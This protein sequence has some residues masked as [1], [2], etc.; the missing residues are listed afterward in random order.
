MDKWSANQEANKLNNQSSDK[1][2]ANAQQ[3]QEILDDSVDASANPRLRGW[4]GWI[5]K[6][7]SHQVSALQAGGEK[8]R[9]KVSEQRLAP[10]RQAAVEMY[11]YA[12]GFSRA[13]WAKGTDELYEEPDSPREVLRKKQGYRV[14]HK[15]DLGSLVNIRRAE[16]AQQ[17][18]RGAAHLLALEEMIEEAD[19]AASESESDSEDDGLADASA[20]ALTS[21]QWKLLYLIG[22]YSSLSEDMETNE[23]WMPQ[24]PLMVLIYEGCINKIFHY[25]YSPMGEYVGRH[26]IFFNFSQ[27]GFSDIS[28]LR[29]RGFIFVLKCTDKSHIPV[30]CYQVSPEGRNALEH[31]PKQHVRKV[32]KFISAP[33]AVSKQ[34]S[35]EDLMMVHWIDDKFILKSESGFTRVTKVTESE[36]VSYVSSPHLPFYVR[37][38]TGERKKLTSNKGRAKESTLG[39]TNLEGE[40]NEVLSFDDV[41]VILSEWLPVG[42]NN[43]K[44]LTTKVG[45][46]ERVST[47][48]YSATVDGA[49]GDTTLDV[50]PGLTN[51]NIVDII[52][53]QRCNL[54]AE[55]YFPE[56]EGIV[57]V[58]NFGVH[59]HVS[60]CVFCGIRI[61]AIQERIKNHISLDSL[62]RVLVDMQQ[63]SSRVMDT[64]LSTRQRAMLELVYR[65]F[66]MNRQKFYIIFAAKLNPSVPGEE[67]LDR[68]KRENELR[69]ILGEVTSAEQIDKNNLFIFGHNGVCV[70]GPA[71]F[72]FE[73]LLCVYAMLH[74]HHMFVGS[75]LLRM[76]AMMDQ[77]HQIRESIEDPKGDPNIVPKVHAALSDLSKDAVHLEEVLLH[78]DEALKAQ[79]LPRVSMDRGDHEQTPRHKVYHLLGFKELLFDLE[80]RSVDVHK[81][82]TALQSELWFVWRKSDDLY[83][84]RSDVI[85]KEVDVN[86]RRMLSSMYQGS[87]ENVESLKGVQHLMVAFLVFGV[88]DR[89]LGPEWSV[90][91]MDW[92]KSQWWGTLPL[93]NPMA[94]LCFGV[95]IWLGI[96][97][98]FNYRLNQRIYENEVGWTSAKVQLNQ[99]VNLD[100]LDDFLDKRTIMSESVEYASEYAMYKATWEEPWLNTLQWGGYA[101]KV[102]LEYDDDNGFVYQ[103]YIKYCSRKGNLAVHELRQLLMDLLLEANV[104]AEEEEGDDKGQQ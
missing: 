39:I 56:E 89:V 64:I 45:A 104:I 41:T 25:D 51:I 103:A 5:E 37:A 94:W 38:Q 67:Y 69:Q 63:D 73:Q 86:T 16:L 12:G 48:F 46:D 79:T 44:N 30:T 74:G 31:I 92:V 33:R 82:L 17:G 42:A 28:T 98:F 4:L 100:A 90:T 75:V 34:K 83:E 36:D 101:P 77:L 52:E 87:K 68:D 80:R 70:I 14:K 1:Y 23:I 49:P 32:D 55:I 21:D 2:Q 93:E 24:T 84:S 47:G 96:F 6:T 3:Q 95:L 22:E 59:V 26:R 60:G 58:E 35:S 76:L 9:S 102:T 62:S 13:R 20:F 72:Q 27:E 88:G 65:G 8:K 18:G 66:Q 11:Q 50:E 10:A 91:A 57:Q 99:A 7:R 53:G 15:K 43:I 97:F 40:Q 81:H 78:S 29:Q 19:A 61:E 85:F 71:R 54:E